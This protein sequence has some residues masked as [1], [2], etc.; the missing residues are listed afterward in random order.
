MIPKNNE[1]LTDALIGEDISLELEPSKTYRLDS[2]KFKINGF[3][4]GLS[5]VRQAAYKILHT[6]RYKYPIYDWNYGIELN[7]LFGMPFPFVRSMIQARI[8][9]ALLADERITEILDFEIEEIDKFS[10]HV[11]YVM[12]TVYG[13]T[14]IDT[15]LELRR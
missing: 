6:E 4:D 9:E 14:D 15:V 7:D 5:A 2:K 1:E 3:V 8:E 12:R 13:D 10:L 11:S